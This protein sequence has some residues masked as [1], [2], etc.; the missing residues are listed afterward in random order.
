MKEMLSNPEIK[1]LRFYPEIH[2]SFVLFCF[3]FALLL[4]Q[5]ILIPMIFHI[6]SS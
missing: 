1:R 3:G 2:E 6:S 5:M 4:T